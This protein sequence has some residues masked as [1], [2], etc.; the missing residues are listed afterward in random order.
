MPLVNFIKHFRGAIGR[1]AEDARCTAFHISLYYALFHLWNRNRFKNPLTISRDEL[2]L[3]SRIGSVNTY[4]KCLKQLHDWAYI[5]YIPSHSPSI[6][7]K[8]HLFR[9]DKTGDKTGGK[10][11]GKTG[12]KTDGKTGN[13][14]GEKLVSPYIN[15]LNNTND[16]N[17][18]NIKN[19]YKPTHEISI[20]DNRRASNTNSEATHPHLHR[21]K[22]TKGGR[23]GGAIPESVEE[24]QQYF[25][26]KKSTATEAEKFFNHYQS[27]GWKVGGRTAMKDW[28]AS[29]RNWIINS[30][31]FNHEHTTRRPSSLH[32][33]TDVDYS[34]P[35]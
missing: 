22:Q 4:Q 31:K 15:I 14:T 19:A 11:S 16:I 13:K 17:N 30:K 28:Q 2:L 9:F 23:R 32:A 25:F 35:L 10:T 21:K 18:L 24:V 6:G 5:Q 29:A 1:F 26:Q 12:N 33:P 34:E 7:S 27:N 3:L 20:F 8:V